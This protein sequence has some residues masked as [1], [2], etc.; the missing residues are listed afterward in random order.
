MESWQGLVPYGKHVPT[1]EA[2]ETLFLYHR[3]V[4]GGSPILMLH[5]L[6]DDADTWRHFIPPL[7]N[8]FSIVAPDLPGFGRSRARKGVRNIAG[9]AAHLLD[10]MTQLGYPYF[11]VFGSSLGAAVAQWMALTVPSRVASLVLL[12]GYLRY[13]SG[14][15]RLKTRLYLLPG[16]GEWLY[17]WSRRDSGEAFDL[18]KPYYSDLDGMPVEDLVFIKRRL[19]ERQ[20]ASTAQRGPYLRLLRGSARWLARERSW[21]HARLEGLSVPVLVLWGADD[22]IVAQEGARD[23]V[24]RVPNGRLVDVE[25]AGHLPQ[26]EQPAACLEIIRAFFSE[27]DY[28]S[29]FTGEDNSGK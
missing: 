10:L 9:L 8:Q 3:E 24:K 27:M 7:A 19:Q 22:R 13:R 21:I 14:K 4:P 6:G 28:P 23:L 26:Q 25:G 17:T 12:D 5:G 2:G 18:L 11:H 16:I 1:G 29:G 20:A 15:V